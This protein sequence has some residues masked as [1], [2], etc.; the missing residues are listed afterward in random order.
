MSPF[1]HPP[2]SLIDQHSTQLLQLT[3]FKKSFPLTCIPFQLLTCLFYMAKFLVR[4]GLHIDSTPVA[5]WLPH[6]YHV[7]KA[8]HT[9]VTSD[10]QMVKSKT[11]TLIQ[12]VTPSFLKTLLASW[13]PCSHSFPLTTNALSQL[14]FVLLF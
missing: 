8:V 12:T 3:L 10:F 7:T 9:K 1:N 14:L 11:L 2:L 4:I 5:L 6:H 13:V